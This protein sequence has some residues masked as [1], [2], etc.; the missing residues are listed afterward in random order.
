MLRMFSNTS[1]TTQ[2]SQALTWDRFLPLGM[3]PLLCGTLPPLPP[4]MPP[5]MPPGIPGIP[6]GMPGM[7]PFPGIP[8][9][10]DSEAARPIVL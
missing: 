2:G 9:I 3:P 10:L 8:G 5:G 1:Q 6:P 7:P 4:G